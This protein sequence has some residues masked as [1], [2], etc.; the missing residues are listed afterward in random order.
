MFS[1]SFFDF[2]SECWLFIIDHHLVF[3]AIAIFLVLSVTAI[4]CFREEQKRSRR[5]N[6]DIFK[7]YSRPSYKTPKLYHNYL[8]KHKLEPLPDSLFRKSE[9]GAHYNSNQWSTNPNLLN[10]KEY[11]LFNEGKIEIFCPKCAYQHNFGAHS[12]NL[13]PIKTKRCEQ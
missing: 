12:V 1:E 4:V 7:P 9:E 8:E 11:S 5:T 3:I 2:L 10:G 13:R 6:K